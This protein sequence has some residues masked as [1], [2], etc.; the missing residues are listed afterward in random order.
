MPSPSR[1]L[2]P[3]LAVLAAAC[4][5]SA[6]EP[7][8]LLTWTLGRQALDRL[9]GADPVAVWRDPRAAG[10]ISRAFDHWRRAEPG[11]MQT[12]PLPP[13]ADL[14]IGAAGIR[15]RMWPAQDWI[16]PLHLLEAESGAAGPRAEAWL[17]VMGSYQ[18]LHP[19]QRS[20]FE[21]FQENQPSKYATFI[22]RNGG[23]MALTN[24]PSE[25]FARAVEAP[26]DPVAAH[27]DLDL[28]QVLASPSCPP[29]LLQALLGS[30]ATPS[31]QRM[32]IAFDAVE[33]VIAGRISLTGLQGR[34][35]RPLDAGLVELAPA[36][37]PILAAASVSPQAL[38]GLF[39]GSDAL[40]GGVL[41]FATWPKGTPLPSATLVLTLRGGHDAAALEGAI[42]AAIAETGGQPATVP[43]AVR[44]WSAVF[45]WG[46]VLV[47]QGTDRLVFGMDPAQ[48]ERILAG[49]PGGSS[50]SGP[51]GGP[52][53][54]DTVA[55]VFCDLPALARDHLP[56]LW[57]QLAAV[58]IPLADLSESRLGV[59][60]EGD[61]I[62][63][64]ATSPFMALTEA[65]GT[66]GPCVRGT[67]LLALYPDQAACDASLSLYR[68]E[69]AP[70]QPDRYRPLAVVRTASDRWRVIP[71]KQSQEF[72]ALQ[73]RERLKDRTRVCGPDPA[74]ARITSVP[75]E[76]QI[77][78][79]WIPP[80]DAVVDHLRPWQ[81][82]MRATAAAV[83]ID[84]RG[85]PVLAVIATVAAHMA[86]SEMALDL[87]GA[88]R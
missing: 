45:P 58:Q 50:V 33:Q 19:A 70:A 22:G 74:Q 61:A 63:L 75:G 69:Q 7:A 83:E 47:A 5:A 78:A 64:A 27:L 67:H 14:L 31:G 77:D 51:S 3:I 1:P 39:D 6:A 88:E 23:R 15:M 82:R 73:L 38:A 10:P 81:V 59:V 43:G 37:T 53:A 41:V 54:P 29:Q 4:P 18:D 12:P 87:S 76:I 44:A 79:R 72:D 9:A 36:G 57:D 26:I 65:D 25:R 46:P 55:V 13:V 42:A 16:A 2:L 84:E 28:A 52:L 62:P 48:V 11:L 49:Q 85:L 56:A 17:R 30:D 86:A 34:P 80:V 66:F 8:P 35:L 24:L 32:R 68:D 71:D 40:A 20:G 21:G 60:V